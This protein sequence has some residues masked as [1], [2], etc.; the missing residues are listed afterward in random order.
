LIGSGSWDSPQEYGVEVDCWSLGATLYVMLLS[1]FPEFNREIPGRPQVKLSGPIWDGVS[2]AAKDMIRALMHPDPAIRMTTE[3]ALQHPWIRDG[4]FDSTAA[5]EAIVSMGRQPHSASGNQSASAPFVS[6]GDS[7]LAHHLFPLSLMGEMSSKSS[8]PATSGTTHQDSGLALVA[9]RKEPLGMLEGGVSGHRDIG[10]A[11]ID[12]NKK[13][14]GLFSEA[15]LLSPVI[16]TTNLI[17]ARALEGRALML[18]TA[19]VLQ[20]IDVTA[21][22]I[23][24]SL[25]DVM[26]AINEDEP[27]LARKIMGLQKSLVS[28]LRE[29]IR[30]M[31]TLNDAMIESVSRLQSELETSQKTFQP[32]VVDMPSDT[33]RVAGDKHEEGGGGGWRAS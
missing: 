1:R 19:Q 11:F 30:R 21:V 17:R 5:S 9:L 15:L 13:V 22:Q 16:A 8:M 12:Y 28:G 24:T 4:G 33:S 2:E 6:L 7:V 23:S 18:E 14:C 27:V 20:K 10:K 25:Q 29:D 31:K 3:Q 32:I 26:F